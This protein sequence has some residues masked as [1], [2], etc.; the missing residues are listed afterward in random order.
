MAF[1][2]NVLAFLYLKIPKCFLIA[3]LCFF[4]F[5]KHAMWTKPTLFGWQHLSW[6]IRGK[7]WLSLASGYFTQSNI[8][9]TRH[10]PINF[11]YAQG[12]FLNRLV[13]MILGTWKIGPYFYEKGTGTT[14]SLSLPWF[15]SPGGY[16]VCKVHGKGKNERPWF[17]EY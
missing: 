17:N 14:F 8:D 11:P 2:Y 9:C 4:S 12:L 5:Q 10:V 6:L 7:S 1:G 16:I 13:P 15:K 3:H